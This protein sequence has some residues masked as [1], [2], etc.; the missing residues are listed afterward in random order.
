MT[1][2]SGRHGP[3]HLHRLRVELAQE[4]ANAHGADHQPAVGWPGGQ[5]SEGRMLGEAEETQEA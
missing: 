3:D 5:A 1:A 4:R 2:E